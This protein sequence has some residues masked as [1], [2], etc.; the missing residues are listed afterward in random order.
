MVIKVI[1]VLAVVLV[2]GG[3]FFYFRSQ[4]KSS[5][6]GL[7]SMSNLQT[8]VI[9]SATGFSP[10]EIKIKVGESVTWINSDTIVHTVHSDPHPAHT[11]YLPL[12]NVGQVPVGQKE[13]FTFTAPGIYEYHDHFN[14]TLRGKVVVE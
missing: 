12:N 9:I 10:A 5:D 2:L 14:S 6:S 11:T 7:A 3:A 13:S 8:R 1:R 4:E